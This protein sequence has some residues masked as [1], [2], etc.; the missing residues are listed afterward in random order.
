MSQSFSRKRFTAESFFSDLYFL[1]PCVLLFAALLFTVR[2]RGQAWLPAARGGTVKH[3]SI[4]EWA[5]Y[6]RDVA[7]E[8]QRAHMEKHLSEGCVTCLKTVQTWKSVTECARQE[9]SY[10][11][12]ASALR[13]AEAYFVPI[14]LAMKQAAGM[15]VARL[16]FDSFERRAAEGIRGSDP[17]PRQLMYKCDEV[18]IDLRLE[19]APLSNQMLLVGQVADPR[20]P[21]GS[22]GGIP[23]S[24]LSDKDTLFQ[25][26]TNEF[27]EFRFS[28]RTSEGLRLLVGT[29]ETSVVVPLPEA[30][31]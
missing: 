13:I 20:Q 16:M 3:F 26:L 25:T 21:V 2:R 1:A 4:T 10:E 9:I 30:E 15:H 27:G 24:L 19:P 8:E 23:V 7:T 29:K 5:D 6:V 22:V 31:A 11:P 28:F 14:K 12:P 18:F 17:L